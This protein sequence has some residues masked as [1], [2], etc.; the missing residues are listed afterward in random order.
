MKELKQGL[1]TGER[2]LYNIFDTNIYDSTFSDGESPLKECMNI[3]IYN[4]IFK[5]KYP[6]WY[7]KNITV[8]NSTLLETARSGIWYTQNIELTDTMIEAPKT[9]RRSK[10]IRLVNCAMPNAS[11]TLWNC[12]NIYMNNVSAKGDYLGFNSKNIE[13]EN[14]KLN[15]N[16]AFDGASNIKIKNAVMLSKD[17]FWNCENVVVENSTIIG[18]YLGWNSKN[19]TFINCTIDSEQGMCYMDNIKMINC[20]LLNTNLAFELCSNIEADIVSHIDSIKNPIS[21]HI[22]AASIG[23][24]VKTDVNYKGK[25]LD[26]TKTKVEVSE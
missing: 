2:A 7:S 24:Y 26:F 5:W 9:F 22:K 14:F 25:N 18:E 20:K 16:Y 6:M 8:S 23:Q 15:G 19:L 11:E 4:S 1:F 17:S 10:D 13:I 21:G 12:E 3:N